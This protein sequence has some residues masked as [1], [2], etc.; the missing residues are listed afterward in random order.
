MP[1]VH[2]MV[3]LFCCKALH[4][5]PMHEVMLRKCSVEDSNESSQLV[6]SMAAP[7]TVPLFSTGGT[8]IDQWFA[9]SSL[10]K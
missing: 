2:L 3:G 7:P 10:D 6:S 1:P 9:S 8:D 4:V 5:L